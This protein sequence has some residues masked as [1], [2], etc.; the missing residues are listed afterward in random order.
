MCLSHLAA[1][2]KVIP[3]LALSFSLFVCFLTQLSEM[4]EKGKEEKEREKKGKKKREEKKKGKGFAGKVINLWQRICSKN[5]LQYP[6]Q[7]GQKSQ[8]ACSALRYFSSILLV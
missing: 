7:W 3:V 4:V 8:V 2:L 5:C 6:L 1:P